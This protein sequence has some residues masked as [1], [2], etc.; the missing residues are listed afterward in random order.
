M[1]SLRRL[2]HSGLLL[3]PVFVRADVHVTGNPYYHLDQCPI[4]IKADPRGALGTAGANSMGTTNGV[5]GGQFLIDLTPT[6]VLLSPKLPLQP[7][8]VRGVASAKLQ[9]GGVG[10]FRAPVYTFGQSNRLVVDPL[11]FDLLLLR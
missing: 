7:D 6:N 1:L 3:L 10:H 4:P 9:G 5:L 11:T 8:T 2:L